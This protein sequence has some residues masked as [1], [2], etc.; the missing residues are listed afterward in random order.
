MSSRPRP[1]VFPSDPPHRVTERETEV[2]FPERTVYCVYIM[3]SGLYAG[4]IDLGEIII[5]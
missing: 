3:D 5:L 1:E 4:N 2:W